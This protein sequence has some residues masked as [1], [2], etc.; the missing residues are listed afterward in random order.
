L[1][2]TTLIGTTMV[3]NAALVSAIPLRSNAAPIPSALID[4]RIHL[5]FPALLEMFDPLCS[6]NLPAATESAILSRNARKL[7]KR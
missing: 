7:F 4:C 3:G 6:L 1:I 2:G 5:S